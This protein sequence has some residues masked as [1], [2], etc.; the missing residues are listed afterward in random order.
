MTQII[1][2]T[3]TTQGS[4]NNPVVKSPVLSTP[5][6]VEATNK[7]TTEYLIYFFFGLIEVLLAFRLIL[8]LTGA[9]IA[10]GFVRF[11]YGLTGIFVLP[12]EG[13]FRKGYAA[14]VETTSVLEPSVVVAIIVYV[15]L[16]WGIVKLLRISTGEKQES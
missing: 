10:S 7:E 15:L 6:K 12:F 11:I 5:V 3:I 1:K 8:K 13:I 9:S 14:G 4:S 16:A 2:E